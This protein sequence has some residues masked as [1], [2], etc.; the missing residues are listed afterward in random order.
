MTS[1]SSPV[2][3]A[4][5]ARL[6]ARFGAAV[7]PWWERLPSLVEELSARWELGLG[8]P[9]GRGNTSLVMRCSRADGR[10]AVLKLA[11]ETSLALAEAWAL[12]S[13]GPSGRVPA[14]YEADAA[15]GAVLL[16]AIPG[17][18]TLLD[19]GRVPGAGEVAV[20]IGALHDAG[21]PALRDGVVTLAERVEFI[22]GH[23]IERHG[24]NDAVVRLVPVSRLERGHEL[25]RELAAADAGRVLLHGDLHPGNVLD[26]G[27]ERG[28]V[29]IDP[30]ACVGDPAFDYVDW[31]LWGTD[32]PGE[33]KA[34]AGRL[35]GD[36]LHDWCR[37]FAALLAASEVSNGLATPGRTEALLAEGAS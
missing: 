8:E 26:G 19:S 23:W 10:P 28:L 6:A 1:F 22:F 14:V 5:R 17:E 32:D 16:E 20:L 25:A 33:W 21:E 15:L 37:A 31:V 2:M 34:R 13:W 4:T 24:R 18:R 30:R 27:A 29:V 36:R 35:G 11:P 3:D 9:V 12:R 7:E